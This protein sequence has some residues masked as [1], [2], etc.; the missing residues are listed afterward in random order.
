MK[1]LTSYILNK[2]YSPYFMKNQGTCHVSLLNMLTI[3]VSLLNM[4]TIDENVIL[5]NI[6]DKLKILILQSSRQSCGLLKI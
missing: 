1:I 5:Q 2:V 4:L 6:D 3:D